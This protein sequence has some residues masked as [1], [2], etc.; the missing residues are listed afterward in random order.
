MKKLCLLCLLAI[1]M[2]F[3]SLKVEGYYCL[4]EQEFQL[5]N[6]DGKKIQGFKIVLYRYAYDTSKGIKI[7]KGSNLGGAKKVSLERMALLGQSVRP[8]SA[9][10]LSL[11]RKPFQNCFSAA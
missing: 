3:A 2:S 4:G 1:S 10:K 8:T 6:K 9:S 5:V 11:F 7:S